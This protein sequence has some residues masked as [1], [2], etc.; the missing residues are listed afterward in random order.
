MAQQ[1]VGTAVG[2]KRRLRFKEAVRQCLF[3]SV[4]PELLIPLTSAETNGM[5]EPIGCALKLLA[6]GRINAR[7]IP[8]LSRDGAAARRIR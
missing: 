6:D 2:G 8:V 3:G 5:A 7:V 4:A 1:P